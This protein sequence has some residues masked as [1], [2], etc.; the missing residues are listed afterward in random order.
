MLNN[1]Q[2]TNQINFSWINLDLLFID[3]D[4]QVAG[5]VEKYQR[6]N[7]KLQHSVI[8]MSRE[9]EIVKVNFWFRW[10]DLT[11]PY[12]EI[13]GDLNLATKTITK[14]LVLLKF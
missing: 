5:E 2:S 4:G 9:L 6:E 7:E 10:L 14:K 13:S 3:K 11:Q 1:Q 8:D 12:K